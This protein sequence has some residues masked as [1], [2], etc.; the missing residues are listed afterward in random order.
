[1][2]VYK[3][4]LAEYADALSVSGNA[5]R[6]NSKDVKV[7]Y[8]AGSRSL[9]CLENVVHRSSRGLQ[10]NFRTL[11][12]EIPDSLK[13]IVVDKSSLIPH[14]QS[15]SHMP[16]TQQRGDKWVKEGLSAVMRVPSVVIAEEYNFILNPAHKDFSKIKLLKVE[17]FEFDSR[18]REG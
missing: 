16:Y 5:A 6:W 17:P 12:I 8:T 11:V 9:A 3:I 14:W 10:G 15:F 4:T 2:I 1:M 18:L 7:I 13:I